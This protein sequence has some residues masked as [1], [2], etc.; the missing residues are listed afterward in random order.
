MAFFGI[1]ILTVVGF[2]AF[3]NFRISQRRAILNSQIEQL[4][5]EIK[6][7]EEKNRQLQVQA[8]ESSQEE[9]LEKE[10]R[11]KLNLKK[12]GEEV[13]AVLPSEEDKTEEPQKQSFWDKILGKIKF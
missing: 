8:Y 5:A 11:E 9:F 10:A 12:P 1:L 13:V 4:K 7:A 6:A 2:L 3:S